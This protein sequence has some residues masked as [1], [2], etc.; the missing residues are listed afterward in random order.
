MGGNFAIFRAIN[1]LAAFVSVVVEIIFLV[2][3]N[4]IGVGIKIGLG[5]TYI[6]YSIS[7]LVYASLRDEQKV[8]ALDNFKYL[9]LAIGILM[10]L[11]MIYPFGPIFIVVIALGADKAPFFLFA[12]GLAVVYAHIASFLIVICRDRNLQQ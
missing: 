12:I 9:L 11:P 6:G 3:M 10:F 8:R 5:C 4:D 2:I 1:I 7:N